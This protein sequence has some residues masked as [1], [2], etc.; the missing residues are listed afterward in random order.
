MQI[1]E[2]LFGTRVRVQYRTPDGRPNLLCCRIEAPTAAQR[3]EGH[4]VMLMVTDDP[5]GPLG[6]R[7]D[8]ITWCQ[9][10]TE[11][12]KD[13]KVTSA[14]HFVRPPLPDDPSEPER[15]APIIQG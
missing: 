8:Q 1:D 9:P 2:V 10:A 12:A 3:E 13:S 7:F 15:F 4:D 11:S 14:P 5:E 6:V